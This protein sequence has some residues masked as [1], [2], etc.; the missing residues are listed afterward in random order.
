MRSLSNLMRADIGLDTGRTLSFRMDLPNGRRQT[1]LNELR[2]RIA[3]TPGVASA[4]YASTQL[5]TNSAWT[6]R[7]SV[8]GQPVDPDRRLESLNTFISPGFFGTMG[9]GDALNAA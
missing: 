2:D 6:S 4:A 7:S 5:L 3:G 9:C 1:Y 8:E